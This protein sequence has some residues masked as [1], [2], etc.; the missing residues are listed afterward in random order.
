MDLP[1]EGRLAELWEK[2]SGSPNRDCYALR[3]REMASDSSELYMLFDEAQY[4]AI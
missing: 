2:T 4:G 3:R 1:V